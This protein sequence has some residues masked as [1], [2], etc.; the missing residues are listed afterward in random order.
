[1]E[2]NIINDTNNIIYIE[3]PIYRENI[4]LKI[5]ND[6]KILVRVSPEKFEDFSII[7]YDTNVD[8]RQIENILSVKF[9]TTNYKSRLEYQIALIEKEEN[10][11]PLIIHQKFYDNNLIYKN[12]IYS[13]GKESI[14]TNISLLNNTNNFI[15]DKNYT[16]IAYGKDYFG[17]SIN[18]FYMKPVSL[19]ISDPKNPSIKE[20]NKT[21]NNI[22]TTSEIKNTDNSVIWSIIDPKSSNDIKETNVMQPNNSTTKL[23]EPT[24]ITSS[25]IESKSTIIESKS[26]I[27]ESK[28]TIIESKSTIIES[29]DEIKSGTII[30]ES[31]ITPISSVEET[32]NPKETIPNFISYNKDDDDNKKITIVIV[33]ASIGGVAILGG[34]IGFIIYYK[35]KIAN[36]AE[37]NTETSINKFNSKN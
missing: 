33:F 15:Y 1:M 34:I 10:I 11:D 21:I 13:P 2:H 32:E 37:V 20:E 22:S 6:V 4:K 19:Y 12:T 17:D 27:I 26:T 29:K 5:E 16:L 3:R 9:N 28:N 35:K 24:S 14:E 36:I 18:Y 7:S 25:H 23:N 30:I 8:I 31:S